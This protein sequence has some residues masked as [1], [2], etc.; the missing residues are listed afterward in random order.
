MGGSAVLGYNLF[1]LYGL[2]LAPATD[3]S[4]LVPALI[5]IVTTLLAWPLLGDRPSARTAV[6]FTIA[7]FGLVLVVDPVGGFGSSRLE[8]DA[9][10]LGAAFCW[11]WYTLAGRAATWRFGSIA[12]NV[13][14]TGAGTLMLLPFSFVLGGWGALG[15]ATAGAWASVVYLGVLG[16]VV[17][18]V[19]FYEG[20]R[21]IGAAR[22][23]AF[24]LL[25]PVF[26]VL[27]SVL[28][29][30]EP[31]RPLLALGGA[32]VLAGLWLVQRPRASRGEAV[33]ELVG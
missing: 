10:L 29:L 30:G 1:F 20:V 18:F 31:L 3:G 6:G 11:P 4:I 33:G 15:G 27:A 17:A 2:R 19:L 13:Y 8:G 16:T 22:A 5:P 26:G 28:V 7:V 9:L 21:E 12:A 24:T 32:I 14:A 23:A 25:V